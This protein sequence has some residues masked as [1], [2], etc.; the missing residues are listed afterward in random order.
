MARAPRAGRDV[1]ASRIGTISRGDGTLQATDAGKPLYRY[2]GDRLPR[3]V[4][5]QNVREF[6]G[7]WL[8][9]RPNGTVVH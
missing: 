7:L 9:V 1:S 3:Q 4:H 8:V 6:G 5:C 2:V